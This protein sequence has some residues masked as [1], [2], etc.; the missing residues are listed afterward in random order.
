MF[1]TT[2]WIRIPALLLLA[3]LLLVPAKD[4]AAGC[5]TDYNACANCARSALWKAMKKLSL[6]GIRDAD[7]QLADCGIDL[8]HCMLYDN[9][10]SYPCAS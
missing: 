3:L 5:L 6:S 2:R 7:I 4:A 9:H 1:A 10:H 8:W